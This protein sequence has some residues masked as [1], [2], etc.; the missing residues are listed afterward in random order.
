MKLLKGPNRILLI[1]VTMTSFSIL[2]CVDH[3]NIER[4]AY[5]GSLCKK[6]RA[7][8][9]VK[10]DWPDSYSELKSWLGKGS[11]DS[12]VE[13]EKYFTVTWTNPQASETLQYSVRQNGRDY[14]FQCKFAPVPQ[15]LIDIFVSDK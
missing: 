11:R 13:D 2:G 9:Q 3:A 4:S 5:A 12:L 14:D 8:R 6:L 7:Y 1:F 10:K 15:D